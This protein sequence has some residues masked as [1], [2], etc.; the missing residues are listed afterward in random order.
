MIGTSYFPISC[1]T[2]KLLLN[3]PC[4]GRH[5]VETWRIQ[6]NWLF[7]IV[8]TTISQSTSESWHLGR[9][10]DALG[11]ALVQGFLISMGFRSLLSPASNCHCNDISFFSLMSHAEVRRFLIGTESS[12]AGEASSSRWD[13]NGSQPREVGREWFSDVRVLPGVGRPS[14][15]PS[16]TCWLCD[17]RQI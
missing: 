8:Q 10:E 11:G 4:R 16:V 12:G 14:W 17:L 7:G 2:L 15:S 1:K 9:Q 13:Q 5:S 3:P 6:S